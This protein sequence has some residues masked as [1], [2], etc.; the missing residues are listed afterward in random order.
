MR[1][2]PNYYRPTNTF[3]IEMSFLPLLEPLYPVNFVINSTN[4]TTDS[5]IVLFKWEAPSGIGPGFFIQSYNVSIT[6]ENSSYSYNLTYGTTM[7]NATLNYNV[8]YTASIVAIN[9]AGESNSFILSN[10][11]YGVPDYPANASRG[12]YSRTTPGAVVTFRC[13]PSFLP[14]IEQF[15]MCMGTGDWHPPPKLHTCILKGNNS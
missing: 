6:S 10:I 4:E 14:T 15:S 13:N 9:C 3:I 5:I 8:N 11:Y 1:P 2:C 7:L 12:N